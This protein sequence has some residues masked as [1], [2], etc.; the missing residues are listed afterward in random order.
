MP[1]ETS[2]TRRVGEQIKRELSAPIRTVA[3]EEAL[4]MI[5]ITAVNVSPD[6]RQAQVLV[7]AIGTE[8]PMGQ[9]I[10]SLNDH[11]GEMRYHLAHAL[12]LRTIPRLGFVYDESVERGMR[13]DRLLD[14]LHTDSSGTEDEAE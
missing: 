11:G 12:S 2:R 5:T 13:M 14:S 6:L 8:R 3:Q 10:A 9:I 1:S 7:T 4:G